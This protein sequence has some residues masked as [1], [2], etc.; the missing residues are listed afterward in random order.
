MLKKEK[1]MLLAHSHWNGH[2][3]GYQETLKKISK[4]KKVNVKVVRGNWVRRE[5]FGGDWRVLLIQT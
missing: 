5:F 3:K 2:Y 4:M 1:A